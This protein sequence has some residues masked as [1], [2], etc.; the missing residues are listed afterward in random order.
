MAEQKQIQIPDDAG[1]IACI[2]D[3][4]TGR[5]YDIPY[6]EDGRRLLVGRKKE[7]PVIPDIEIETLDNCMSGNQAYIWI[8]KNIIGE[9]A[10]YI[11]DT[12][13]R[14]NKSWVN[15]VIIDHTYKFQVYDKD[16][17]NLGETDFL[18]RFNP[19]IHE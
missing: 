17:I 12:P 1:T 11:Q 4:T 18:V 15:K 14:T 6:R 5:Q 16:V 2:I 19:T 13:T 10:L 7:Q 8:E 3:K 9:Y